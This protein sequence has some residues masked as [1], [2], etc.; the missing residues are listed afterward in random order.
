MFECV[1]RCRHHCED[2][3][4]NSDLFFYGGVSN[5]LDSS[6]DAKQH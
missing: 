3:E 1:L 5:V 2:A 4:Q 6:E